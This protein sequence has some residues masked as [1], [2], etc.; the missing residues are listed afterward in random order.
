MRQETCEKKIESEECNEEH[1]GMRTVAQRR[2]KDSYQK[3]GK[4]QSVI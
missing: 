4:G 1:S 2:L 3:Y